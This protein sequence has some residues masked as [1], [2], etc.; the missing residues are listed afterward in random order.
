[1][2]SIAIGIT[3]GTI[4]IPLRFVPLSQ[5]GFVYVPAFGVGVLAG[6]SGL[7]AAMYLK[8]GSLPA[9]QWREAGLNGVLSGVL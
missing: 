3:G 6:C 7:I 4:F 2:F 5:I 1:M 8:D 9:F